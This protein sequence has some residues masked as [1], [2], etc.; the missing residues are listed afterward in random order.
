M[1]YVKDYIDQ[2]SRAGAMFPHQAGPLLDE[3]RRRVET[4]RD[5]TIVLNYEGIPVVGAGFINSIYALIKDPLFVS[6]AKSRGLTFED[7]FKGDIDN[8]RL[9]RK[10]KMAKYFAMH[11]EAVDALHKIFSEAA[12]SAS[13]YDVD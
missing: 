3:I 6:E 9:K 12:A 2:T 13:E 11:P 4:L 10:I 7:C 5:T 8:Q 1:L